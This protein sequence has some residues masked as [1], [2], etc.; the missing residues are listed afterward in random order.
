MHHKSVNLAKI[1]LAL[2]MPPGAPGSIGAVQMGQGRLFGWNEDEGQQKTHLLF[3]CN[4][5]NNIW[6]KWIII[7]FSLQNWLLNLFTLLSK[8]AIKCGKM[9]LSNKPFELIHCPFL[10]N[11]D[12]HQPKLAIWPISRR[13]FLIN[14]NIFVV[15]IIHSPFPPKSRPQ[16]NAK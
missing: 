14:S 4:K 16:S 1:P 15:L 12:W 13:S 11:F 10:N 5:N 6:A 8:M 2:I 9:C 3:Y 7:P